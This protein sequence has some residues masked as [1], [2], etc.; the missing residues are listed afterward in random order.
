MLSGGASFGRT[1]GDIYCVVAYVSACTSVL[2]NPN[3][4]FR[5]GRVGN[6]TPYTFRMSGIYVL[7]Y[8][9]WVSATAQHNAGFPEITTV[10]V[11]GNTV[12]LTQV[13]QSL[14]VEPRGTTRLPPLNSIDVSVK[15]SFKRG[16]VSFEPRLDLYNLTNAATIL[17]RITQLGPT[18]GRVN[19]IQKGRLIKVGF[20]VDF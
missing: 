11:S 19:S 15:R 9:F 10:S 17:G 5:N 3:F 7:P 4:T 1:D 2:N 12:A 18:Y 14:V 8:Q 6:D 13:T 20:N 16:A